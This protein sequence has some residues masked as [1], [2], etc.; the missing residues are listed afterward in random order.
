MPGLMFGF[1]SKPF[2][3]S[4]ALALSLQLLKQDILLHFNSEHAPK[5][6]IKIPKPVLYLP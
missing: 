2:L 4:E 3:S 5:I 1:L 6:E